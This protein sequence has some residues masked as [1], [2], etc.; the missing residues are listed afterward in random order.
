MV[1]KKEQLMKNFFYKTKVVFIVFVSLIL[2]VPSYSFSKGAPDS[3]ADLADKLMPSV[4]NIA[5]TRVVEARTQSPFPFQ[6]PPGSPFEDFFKEFNQQQGAPQ[7]RKSTALGSGFVISQDGIVITNNHVIQGAEGILVKFTDGK[8]YEAK[9]VGTDPVSDI[10]VLKIQSSNKFKPVALGDSGKSRVGDWV[11]AIGNPFGLGGTVTSGIISAINRDIN[12]GR[13]DNFIQTDASI[14]QGNSGGPLFNMNGEVV[15][16]NTA[17]FSQSGGSVGIG[18]AIPANFAKNVIEQLR[19]YGETRRGWL[20][21]RIQEVTKEIADSLGMKE[22]MGALVADVNEK[23][24]AKKAGI[25]E[26]DVII[27]FNGIKIDTMRKLPKVVGEAPVG[28]EATL[29]IWRDKKVVNKTIILGRLEDTDEF[30]T[31]SSPPKSEKKDDVLLKSLGAK[32]RDITSQDVSA[33]KLP[34][35]KNGVIVQEIDAE[36]ALADSTVQVGDVI[37]ALQNNKIVNAADFANKI[38]KLISSGNKSLLLTVIDSQN[39][40]RYVGV[41]IK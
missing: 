24:P 26:G 12:M 17:I 15:G 27:E 40:S 14:N 9:L 29:K 6:F 19:K 4:V 35:G 28:K 22:E 34:T 39:R 16:I 41:K 25:K 21:V 37:V 30:K 23:S 20:G 2:L 36:G 11:L 13:Y 5:A 32:V 33:R 18:F 1:Y 10:A 3:F 38:K 7:K 8:E 31:K